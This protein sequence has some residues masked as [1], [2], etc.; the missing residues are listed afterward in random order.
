MCPQTDS[1]G[2]EIQGVGRIGHPFEN[3]VPEYNFSSFKTGS[4][5]HAE[6][7]CFLQTTGN[8]PG[9]E[10]NVVKRRF[11]KSLGQ[12]YIPYKKASPRF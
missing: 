5:N 4:V 3:I 1:Q 6:K 11:G 2:P 12:L 8:S 10:G 7:V 9:P